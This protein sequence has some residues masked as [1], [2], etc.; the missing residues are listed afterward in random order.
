M[1]GPS[2]PILSISYISG[3]DHD[4]KSSTIVVKRFLCLWSNTPKVLPFGRSGTTTLPSLPEQVAR[5]LE[6][7]HLDW[8]IR[9][10]QR[11]S[12]PCSRVT[13]PWNWVDWE[14]FYGY[15]SSSKTYCYYF[16]TGQS[17]GGGTRSHLNFWRST[18]GLHS[19]HYETNPEVS[20]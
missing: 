3:L 6:S 14:S 5:A 20:D 1:K 17:A 13:E 4:R 19:F 12:E 9:N 18:K 15:R 11:A 8:K 10:P 16:P 2:I 7:V